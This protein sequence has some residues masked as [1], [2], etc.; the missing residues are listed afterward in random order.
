MKRALLTV[1]ALAAVLPGRAAEPLKLVRTIP[2]PGVEGRID[3]LGVDLVGHRL[4]VAALGNNTV[5]V[6]DLNAGQRI[7]TLKSLREPQ[8]VLFLPSLNRI[9]VAN[10]EDGKV[11]IFE[12]TSFRPLHT[13]EFSGD[14]DNIRYDAD[15]RQAYIGYGSGA[16]GIVDVG[17]MARKVGDIPLEGHPESFQLEKSGTRIFVNVPT[18]GHIAVI[19]RRARAVT[20]KWP[21]PGNPQ[22][23]PMAL[24]ED[25]HRL[26]AGCRKPA[27]V[28]VIDT[29]TGKIVA[30]IDCVGDTDDLFYDAALRRLYVSGGE[31][32]LS[33]FQEQNPDHYTQLG[34]IPTAAGARTSL[35]VP[36]LKRFYLAVPHRG[37]QAAGVRVYET[38]P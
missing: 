24:D 38:Q 34:K 20:L 18:A 11:T 6:V 36:N 19:D 22:N 25:E 15:A 33:V 10:G 30:Q 5:E 4:F 7:L 32:F 17:A 26:F 21:L 37:A 14:A 23:F 13:I 1:L 12:G 31:G 2:L 3:H 8:G 9:Y 27:H 29:N 16:L 35:F 28:A